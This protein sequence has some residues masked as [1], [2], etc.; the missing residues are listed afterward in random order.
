MCLCND[1]LSIKNCKAC[2]WFNIIIMGIIFRCV[3]IQRQWSATRCSSYHSA[4]S[5][6]PCSWCH[7]KNFYLVKKVNNTRIDNDLYDV[8]GLVQEKRNSIVNALKLGF[9]C[10]NPSMYWC[11]FSIANL[12][13]DVIKWKHFPRYWPFVRGIHRWPANSPHKCQWRGVL[14]F[15][16][17][18][19]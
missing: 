8:D 17:I 12:R 2:Y 5:K 10:T 9:S 19:A 15:S 7:W 6:H 18:C 11:V 3:W 14:T 13:D 1:S 16:M 4:R